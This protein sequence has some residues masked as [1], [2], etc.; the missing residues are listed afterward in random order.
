VA[1]YQGG[2]SYSY[3]LGIPV[4]DAVLPL[5]RLTI[6]ALQISPLP[7]GIGPLIGTC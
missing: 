5:I 1:V 7:M 4:L 2:Q 6:S 3:L